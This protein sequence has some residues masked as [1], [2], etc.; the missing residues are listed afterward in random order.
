LHFRC[1]GSSSNHTACWVHLVLVVLNCGQDLLNKFQLN[2]SIS[3][4]GGEK[5]CVNSISSFLVKENY[6]TEW[7]GVVLVSS[8]AVRTEHEWQCQNGLTCLILLFSFSIGFTLVHHLCCA[9]TTHQFDAIY[10]P[11]KLLLCHKFANA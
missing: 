10:C 11:I 1:H 5:F 6:K 8:V 4:G 3:S 9:Y 7:V 2:S